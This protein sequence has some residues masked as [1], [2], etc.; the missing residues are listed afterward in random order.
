MFGSL[1]P[2]VWAVVTFLFVAFVLLTTLGAFTLF[3]DVEFLIVIGIATIA[4]I[5]VAMRSSRSTNRGA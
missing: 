4:A 5:A 3:G 1:I 2:L